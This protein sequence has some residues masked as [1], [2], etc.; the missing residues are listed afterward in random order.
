MAL[1]SWRTLPDESVEVDRGTGMA[2]EGSKEGF[3]IRKSQERVLQWAQLAAKYSKKYDV[4][5]S[6]ILAVVFA[7][8]GGDPKA[9]NPCCVGLM[10]IHLAAHGKTR[11]DMKDPDKN[12]DYGTSLL[13]AS[14]NAGYDLPASA[15]IHVAGGGSKFKPHAG[16][17]K[18][19]RDKH[20]SFPTGSPW[21]MCEH[22]FTS[23]HGDGSV[24]YIDRVVR[25]NNS[26]VSL[27]A[28]LSL[29]NGPQPP[30]Q[31]AGFSSPLPLVAGV[32]VGFI[33]I[34]C[35]LG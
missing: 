9:E 31:L 4:P 22:M 8:S 3:G 10:A 34:Q 13:A 17:C 29:P 30:I 20:P 23:T 27:L 33:A 6:W 24:G 16:T 35:G 19:A 2:L 26:F 1:W 32:A 25:A 15:S 7:E 14:R 5:A 12:M 18:S 11:A 28:G 21:G